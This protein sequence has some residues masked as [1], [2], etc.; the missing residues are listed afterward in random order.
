MKKKKTVNYRLLIQIIF[1]VLIAFISINK[2]L[3][4]T[5]MGI[6]FLAATSLHAICPFGGVETLY[7]FF[8]SGLLLEKVAMSSLILM[9]LVFLLAL[10]FGPVFCGWVCPLG[11]FQ[12]WI[13]KLGK[14]IF[15][16]KYNKFIPDKVHNIL[17]FFR[18]F[19]LVW[20]LYITARSGSLLFL[21][22]DP[23]H[24]LFKFYTGTVAIQAL[25]VLIT[26][27][28]LSLF[29]ERP[30]CKYACPFGA[31]LGLFNKI[32]IFKLKRN[33]DTCISCQKC[34]RVCPM[35]INICQ[36]D[37]VTNV[38]CIS[39]MACTSIMNCPKTDTLDLQITGKKR[40]LKIKPALLS[41][42]IVFVIFG[43]ILI[44]SLLGLWQSSNK[45]EADGNRK[46]QQETYS[47]EDQFNQ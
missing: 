7:T 29:V 22:I 4:Q 28:V 15:K 31:V 6:S 23:Y 27:I 40:T 24:A 14:K 26:I 42:I 19:L 2:T 44:S 46:N 35:K 9:A 3:V 11:S 1:F 38:N 39:C 8:S 30:W 17:R 34:S 32:R 20:V 5:G 41:I 43:G 18:Y 25:L 13:G 47:S 36:N 37:T 21:N 16:K 33:N 10:L 45:T 12:E